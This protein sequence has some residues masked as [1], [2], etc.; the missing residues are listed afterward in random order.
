MARIGHRAAAGAILGVVLA[1]LATGVAAAAGLALTQRVLAS[2]QL[3]GMKST[4]AP[5]A[6]KGA[7][8]FVASEGGPPAQRSAEVARLTKLGFIAAVREP[9]VS[10]GN[11]NLAGLSLVVQFASSASAKADLAHESTTNGPW[12]YFTVA[13]IPGARGFESIQSAG[14]GRN[15][16]FTDGPFYYLVGAGWSGSASNG[17]PRSQV[18]S[19]ALALYR[20]V[21]GK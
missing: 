1:V 18:I 12:K 4:K 2:G 6:V 15:V 16:G 11:G 14:G 5:V 13:G 10:P 7:A 21:H 19:T 17:V 3:A 20:R 8:A 9:L